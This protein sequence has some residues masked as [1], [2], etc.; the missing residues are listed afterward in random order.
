MKTVKFEVVIDVP[1]VHWAQANSNMVKESIKDGLRHVQLEGNE[2][3]NVSVTQ[4]DI[5]DRP[6]IKARIIFCTRYNGVVIHFDN[7]TPETEEIWAKI[8]ERISEL[9][10]FTFK[11][12]RKMDPTL[13][14][15][16]KQKLMKKATKILKEGVPNVEFDLIF[17]YDHSSS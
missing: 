10:V 16:K 12:T 3:I 8:D 14:E 4:L 2:R 17:E 1:N 9:A 6:P 13:S 15:K 5:Q 11:W 7:D